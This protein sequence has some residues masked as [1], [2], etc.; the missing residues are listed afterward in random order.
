VRNSTRAVLA[1]ASTS[2]DKHESPPTV[3]YFSALYNSL[4]N[5][6]SPSCKSLSSGRFPNWRHSRDRQAEVHA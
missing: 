4:R 3:L 6:H 1:C 2:A 5:E